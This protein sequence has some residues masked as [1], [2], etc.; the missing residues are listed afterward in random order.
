MQWNVWYGL[1]LDWSIHKSNLWAFCP[2]VVRNWIEL[3]QDLTKQFHCLSPPS[4]HDKIHFLEFTKLGSICNCIW[5][6]EISGGNNTSW[7]GQLGYIRNIC[8]RSCNLSDQLKLIFKRRQQ[9]W[10]KLPLLKVCRSFLLTF[11]LNLFFGNKI[12]TWC[13]Q[14][15]WRKYIHLVNLVYLV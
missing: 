4:G 3:F 15:T 8:W 14:C 9:E 10:L 12:W 2:L 1:V 13:S 6:M 5:W 11:Y 7:Y